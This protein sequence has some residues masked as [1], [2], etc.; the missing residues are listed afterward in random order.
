MAQWRNT[1]RISLHPRL[2][3]CPVSSLSR[4]LSILAWR[5]SAAIWRNRHR[6]E[7]LHEPWLLIKSPL[8][9]ACMDDS[10]LADAAERWPC[11][12]GSCKEGYYG[13]EGK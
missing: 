10:S 9:N 3:S 12:W 1:P 5:I 4:L 8:Y 11:C 2:F 7:T 6:D 13:V